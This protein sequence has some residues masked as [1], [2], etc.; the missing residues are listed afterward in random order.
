MAGI[1]ARGEHGCIRWLCVD[2][3][4]ASNRYRQML[5]REPVGVQVRSIIHVSVETLALVIGVRLRTKSA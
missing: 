3:L 5:V 2:G 4:R 1:E